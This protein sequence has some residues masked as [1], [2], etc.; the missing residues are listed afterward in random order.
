MIPGIRAGQLYGYRVT[1]PFAPEHGLGFDPS[2]VLL[3]PYGRAVAVP[4]GYFRQMAS[5]YG[6]T[7]RLR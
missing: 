2:K 6:G 5:E 1:G 4:D 7:M 3:D